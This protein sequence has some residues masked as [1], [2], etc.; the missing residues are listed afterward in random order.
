LTFT[1]LGTRLGVWFPEIIKIWFNILFDF[2][3]KF[4]SFTPFNY[5]HN[6]LGEYVEIS[7]Q[8]MSIP[9]RLICTFLPKAQDSIVAVKAKIIPFQIKSRV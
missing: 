7:S 6:L 3:E 9:L 8:T 5:I 1:A 4:K 2:L